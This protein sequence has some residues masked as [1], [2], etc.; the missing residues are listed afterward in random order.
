M[1]HC[2]LRVAVHA[3]AAQHHCC[4]RQQA[5]GGQ[6]GKRGKHGHQGLPVCSSSSAQ[7]P[8]ATGVSCCQGCADVVKVD[9]AGIW[10]AQAGSCDCVQPLSKCKV[11][12]AHFCQ[13]CVSCVCRLQTPEASKSSAAD[14]R[15]QG[16]PADCALQAGFTAGQLLRSGYSTAELVQSAATLDKLRAA[17]VR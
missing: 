16:L 5:A 8:Q 17:G 14:Y 1:Q 4:V 9:R 7:L 13:Y 15:Q 10:G 2:A 6:A 11:Q 3:G 12:Y